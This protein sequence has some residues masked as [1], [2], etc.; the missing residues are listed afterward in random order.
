MKKFF[1]ILVLT[2]L[3]NGNVFGKEVKIICFKDGKLENFSLVQIN[4]DKNIIYWDDFKYD[5]VEAVNIWVAKQKGTITGHRD[6]VLIF[7]NRYT[8]KSYVQN[9]DNVD[10]YNCKK[11]EKLF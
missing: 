3:F 9:S 11:E 4:E 7:I 2:I 8:F 6:G 10:I 1:L 5:I